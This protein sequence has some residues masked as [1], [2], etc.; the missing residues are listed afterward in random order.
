MKAALA[1]FILSLSSLAFSL[2]ESVL[3][4]CFAPVLT[5]QI[6]GKSWQVTSQEKWDT[7]PLNISETG[8]ITTAR[9]PGADHPD[10]WVKTEVILLAPP[11]TE[12]NPCPTQTF[13]I[14]ATPAGITPKTTLTFTFINQAHLP[15]HTIR[16]WQGFPALVSTAN[17][18]YVIVRDAQARITETHDAPVKTTVSITGCSSEKR[19]PIERS[20]LVGEGPL[21]PEQKLK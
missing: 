7:S 17:D 12:A 5:D 16:T 13:T 6:S 10:G 4:A 11:Q 8:G 14:K 18:W 20:I 3:E 9:L 19:T 2:P 1:L 21:P 15:P